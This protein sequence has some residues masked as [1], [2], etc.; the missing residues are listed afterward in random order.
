MKQIQIPSEVPDWVNWIAQDEDGDWY[1]YGNKPQ[2]VSYGAWG[3][4]KGGTT[5]LSFQN[6]NWKDTLRKV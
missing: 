4:G 1:G 5:K 6:S 3:A 2:N